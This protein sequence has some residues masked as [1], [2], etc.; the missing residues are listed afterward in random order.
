[1]V[2]IGKLIEQRLNE[3]GMS[4]AEFARRIN[5][6]RQNINDLFKRE[7]IDVGF[8]E[9]IGE[10]LNYDFFKH[11]VKKETLPQLNEPQ[12]IYEKRDFD[13]KISLVIELNGTKEVEDKY[14]KLISEINRTIKT[15]L[16]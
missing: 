3:S 5:K 14:I 9:E 4:K 15:Y 16:I 2:M 13:K 11:F 6:S 7:T 10:V 12:A 8:L 1:M